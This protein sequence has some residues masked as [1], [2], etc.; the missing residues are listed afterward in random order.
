[1]PKLASKYDNNLNL[2]FQLASMQTEVAMIDTGDTPIGMMDEEVWQ[3]T[4]DILL[5]QKFISA[6]I[7]LKTMYTNE[8]VEK[9]Q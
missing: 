1:M 2:E 4:Q 8:F 6:P 7:D 5:E 3:S 9:V